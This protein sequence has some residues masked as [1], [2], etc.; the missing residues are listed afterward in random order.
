MS[1]WTIDLG[2]VAKKMGRDINT[3]Q[4]GVALKVFSQTVMATPV[5]TG[6]LRANWQ[7]A[8]GP[9]VEDAADGTDKTGSATVAKI[10]EVVGRLQLTDSIISIQNNL[11]YAG[12]IEFDGWSKVKAPQGMMRIS[13][14]NVANNLKEYQNG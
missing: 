7:C 3:V 9:P 11:P 4:R 13:I 14:A 2:V 5:L 6:A 8:I 1:A 10:S 12:R